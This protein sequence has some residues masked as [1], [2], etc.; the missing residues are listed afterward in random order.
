MPRSARIVVPGVPLH[1]TQRGVDRGPTFLSAEDYAM[2][3]L[4]VRTV[5]EACGCAL[6]AYVLMTNHVHL[7]LTPVAAS[8][9][10]RLMQAVGRR[11]VR[12]FNTRHRR[13]GTLWEG[14]F[15]SSVIESERHLF[16]CA[17]YIENNPVRAGMVPHPGLYAWSSFA[18]NAWGRRDAA[19]TPH[20]SYLA[21]ANSAV[22]RRAAY[23]ALFDEPLDVLT[24]SRLRSEQRLQPPLLPSPYR[25]AVMALYASAADGDAGLPPHW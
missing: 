24:V 12:Y 16:A 6:H 13:S 3:L 19:V 5:S 22:G 2:Y 21:L 18:H 17:R 25:E 8:A 15:R 20:A 9:P 10:S 11:Y 4:A 23:R 7:L 14:R 1:V